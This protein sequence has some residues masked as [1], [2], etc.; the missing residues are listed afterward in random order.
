MHMPI[1]GGTLLHVRLPYFLFT[2][3]LE[4]LILRDME[5]SVTLCNRLLISCGAVLI[6]SSGSKEN[7]D[8]LE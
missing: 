2:I 1:R 3:D 5:N 7:I 8:A 4:L 6:R